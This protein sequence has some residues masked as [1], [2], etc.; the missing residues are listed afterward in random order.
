[1]KKK[2]KAEFVKWFGPILDALRS[3]E[4]SAKPREISLWIGEQYNIPDDILNERYEKS[5]VLKFQN[6]LAWARQYLVWEELLETGK[7]GYWTISKKGRD[8]TLN[9]F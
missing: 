4:G 9:E 5:G 8:V 7:H 3:L 2:G 6:Q 1:M